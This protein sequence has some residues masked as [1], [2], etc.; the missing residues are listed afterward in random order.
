MQMVGKL[1]QPRRLALVQCPFAFW[2]VAHE[3]LAE[4]R[5]KSL[6]VFGEVVAVFKIKF[7]LP[8]LLGGTRSGKT[9][10]RCVAQDG[11]AELFV[12]K[13]TALFFRRTSGNGGFESVVDHLL[14]GSDFGRLRR[15]QIT[16]PAEHLRLERT[17]MVEGQNVKW[18]IVAECP[19][20]A[21]FNLR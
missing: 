5:V 2:I 1:F 14:G 20:F 9:I 16:M 17:A 3:D 15:C 13:D 8:A 4:C 21:S 10:R 18:L 19:H 11:R 7:L 12:H 6:N